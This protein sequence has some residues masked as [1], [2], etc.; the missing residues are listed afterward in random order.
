MTTLPYSRSKT[1]RI[2]PEVVF[3]W[4]CIIAYCFM[5]WMIVTKIGLFL[6]LKLT[7]GRL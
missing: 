3:V 2:Q 6:A 7:G 1:I 4:S 5:F